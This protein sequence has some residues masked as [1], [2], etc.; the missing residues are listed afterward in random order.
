MMMMMMMMMMMVGGEV[1]CLAMFILWQ[2]FAPRKK[3]FA[4]SVAP[5]PLP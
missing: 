1:A 4:V 2:T 5:I 3:T